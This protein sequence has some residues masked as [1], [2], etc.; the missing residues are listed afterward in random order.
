VT[1]EGQL[2]LAILDLINATEM[3]W[4]IIIIAIVGGIAQA[5][6]Q[7]NKAA[8]KRREHTSLLNSQGYDT[9]DMFEFDDSVSVALNFETKMLKVID[10]SI[11][12]RVHK[13]Q[14]ITEIAFSNIRDYEIITD[15]TTVFKKSTGAAVGRA[16]VGG[17]LLGGVGAV[18]GAVTTSSKGKEDIKAANF[19][20][21][22]NDVRN[23]SI[24]IPI[25]NK[26]TIKLLRKPFTDKAQ[27]LIDKLDILIESKN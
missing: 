10:D 20:I 4:I 14:R 22:T 27:R 15:G 3:F 12:T 25:F 11:D 6:Y 13:R 21:F 9:A 19:K 17:L 1:K 2:R 18:A 23:P 16:L 24:M 26:R 5:I 8:G 7:G